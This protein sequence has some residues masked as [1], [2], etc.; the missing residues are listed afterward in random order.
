MPL[1]GTPVAVGDKYFNL[2]F[3]RLHIIFFAHGEGE[4]ERERESEGH[5]EGIN[6]H[7]KMG[8]R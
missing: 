5:R 6:Q 7:E 2:M 3:F 8:V 4:G 1:G